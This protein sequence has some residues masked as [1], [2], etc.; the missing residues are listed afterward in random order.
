MRLLR[1]I[2]LPL[3][4]STNGL[5]GEAHDGDVEISHHARNWERHYESAYGLSVASVNRARLQRKNAMLHAVRYEAFIKSGLGSHIVACDD[6]VT[7]HRSRAASEVGRPYWY[8]FDT[9]LKRWWEVGENC[10]L[11]RSAFRIGYT[12]SGPATGHQPVDPIA[13]RSDRYFKDSARVR[14]KR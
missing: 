4:E 14:R 1:D 10:A 11:Q 5:R 2:E 3:Q 9:R 12:N 8:I 7:V 6:Y 13:K